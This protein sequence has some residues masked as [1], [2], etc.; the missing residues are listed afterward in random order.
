MKCLSCRE[1]RATFWMS[2]FDGRAEDGYCRVKVE[3]GRR[4]RRSCNESL[5]K[6][7]KERQ[8]IVQA[9][10]CATLGSHSHKLD[11]PSSRSLNAVLASRS[12]AGPELRVQQSHF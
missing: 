1:I 6:G 10:N 2:L 5:G 4:V 12:A 7:W 11:P 3:T 8:D 9:V